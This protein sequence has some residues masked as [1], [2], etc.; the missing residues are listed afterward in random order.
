MIEEG[1]ENTKFGFIPI[2]KEQTILEVKE[3]NNNGDEN[4]EALDG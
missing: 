3:E 1:Q 2:S 4:D